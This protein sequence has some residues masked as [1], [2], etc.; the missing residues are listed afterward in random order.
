VEVSRTRK[1]VPSSPHWQ[2]TLAS[3]SLLKSAI[4]SLP[5]AKNTAKRRAGALPPRTTQKALPRRACA[6]LGMALL[7]W[8]VCVVGCRH[9]AF[10]QVPRLTDNHGTH[11]RARHGPKYVTSIALET[12][13]FQ[14]VGGMGTVLFTRLRGA[15]L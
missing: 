13:G 4:A 11:K 14:L 15:R 1:S 9:H 8:S 6:N 2:N 10:R 3:Y 12:N 7:S 5:S